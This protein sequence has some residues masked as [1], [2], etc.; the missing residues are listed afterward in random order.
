M[1]ESDRR[2]LNSYLDLAN[3]D[4]QSAIAELEKL[5]KKGHRQK[6]AAILSD[7]TRVQATIRLA[8]NVVR[9]P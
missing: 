4:I 2:V 9:I 1:T 6:L 3:F 8:R 5:G 7:V